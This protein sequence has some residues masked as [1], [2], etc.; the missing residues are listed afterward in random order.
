MLDWLENLIFPERASTVAG[1]VDALYLFLIGVAGFF[2]VLIYVLV[3]YFAVRYRRSRRPRA[4][5]VESSLALELFWSGIPF[6]LAMVMFVWGAKLY[7]QMYSVPAVAAEAKIF[8]VGKQWMWK[9]HHPEGPR[10]INELHVPVGRPTRLVMTSEDV[11]HSFYVPAFRIKQDVLPGRYVQLWFEATKVG[12]YHLFC[13]EYCGTDHAQMVG[14]I[15]VMEP[16]AYQEW[17]RSEATG[18]SMATAG[19]QLYVQ[20]GC[21]SCHTGDLGAASPPLL[22]RYGKRVALKSGRPAAMDEEYI[23]ESIL[24]PGVQVASGYEPVMPPYQ[25]LISEEGILQIVEYLKTGG[26]EPAA[27]TQPV[28][29]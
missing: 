26:S 15:V 21:Q 19:Q 16:A 10:E 18:P 4:E 11:I 27:Q 1:E 13:A 22:G 12:T 20:L 9:I 3:I 17:L 8:V 25:G 6:L 5:Q 24:N 29:R 14:R 28:G 7:W 2:T 23:R